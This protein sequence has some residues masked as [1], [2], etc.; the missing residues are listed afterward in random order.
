MQ[1]VAMSFCNVA[2][3]FVT[4]V[5]QWRHNDRDGVSDHRCLDCLLSRLFRGRSKKTSKPR[6]TGGFHLQMASNAKKMLPF[7]D[8]II[9]LTREKW[10]CRHFDEIYVIG[11]AESCQNDNFRCSNWRQFHRNGDIFVSVDCI[12]FFSLLYVC[13]TSVYFEKFVCAK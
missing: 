11:S 9:E 1:S 5:L 7:D 12:I 10:K 3:L 6:V 4:K 13:T 2:V 8:V